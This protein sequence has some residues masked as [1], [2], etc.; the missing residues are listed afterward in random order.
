MSP[1]GTAGDWE[2]SGLVTLL[3]DFGTQDPYVGIMKGVLYGRASRLRGIVDLGHELP[4]QDVPTAA[5][6]LAHARPWFPPGTVHVC[7]VDPG[8][9]S[10]R[11]ILVLHDGRDVF[12]APDNG[13]LGPL[14]ERLQQ[15]QEA[16]QGG[17]GGVWELD[18]ERF[19]LPERS[20]TFHG[21][22]V[23]T[24]A[25]A[26][27]VDGLAPSQM[28]AALDPGDL[29]RFSFP[30]FQ[31]QQGAHGGF[32]GE[33]LLVDRFGNLIT[34]LPGR[35]F[36]E[37]EAWILSAAGRRLPVRGTYAEARAGEALA[38]VDSYGLLEIAIRNG[39]AAR[40]LEMGRGDSVSVSPAP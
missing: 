30:D 4:P 7:V 6:Q 33:V 36:D 22:D 18:I 23:F 11:R 13:V 37:S 14:L 3:T 21:R 25:A 35:L 5:F 32:T 10:S 27:L 24:P 28:G 26:H 31:V 17:A 20:R 38:L 16:G 8:V 9:G 40:E 34:N 39:D 29:E 1:E 12:L 19:G 2:P 15:G